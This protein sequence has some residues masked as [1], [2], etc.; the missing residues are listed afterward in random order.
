MSKFERV[1]EGN[2][3]VAFK[4]V[5]EF[6]NESP[7]FNKM[8]T[9]S[10]QVIVEEFTRVVFEPQRIGVLGYVDEEPAGLLLGRMTTLLFS[11]GFIAQDILFYV[12]PKFRSTLLVKQL[13]NQFEDWAWSHP[14]CVLVQLT[15]LANVDNE[16]AATLGERLGF[17]R[18]GFVLVKERQ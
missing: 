12:R 10:P 13:V 6:L 1:D 16:R 17:Q 9:V 4:M 11:T 14:E 2:W 7:M 8:P 15:A 5:E 3:Y 18:V